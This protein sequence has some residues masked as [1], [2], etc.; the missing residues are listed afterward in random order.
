VKLPAD[1]VRILKLSVA[2]EADVLASPVKA[3]CVPAVDDKAIVCVPEQRDVAYV[4]TMLNFVERSIA[5]K[6]ESF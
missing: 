5:V 6:V 4:L 1:V 2:I 3:V